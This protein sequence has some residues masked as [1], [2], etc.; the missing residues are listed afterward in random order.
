[1][2]LNPAAISESLGLGILLFA[3]ASPGKIIGIAGPVLRLLPKSDALLLGISM[4]PRAEIALVIMYQCYQLDTNIISDVV[5][6]AMVLMSLATSIIILLV[7]PSV[8]AQKNQF[9]SC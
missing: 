3:T 1:M 8:M 6:A 7:L 9:N 5:F 4:V 2:Q